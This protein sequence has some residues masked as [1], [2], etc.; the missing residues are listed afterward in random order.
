MASG[1]GR[2]AKPFMLGGA[3][4]VAPDAVWHSKETSTPPRVKAL[5]KG[6]M[7]DFVLPQLCRLAERPPGG[8]GWGHEI[9]F[10]GYRMQLRIA[11]GEPTLRTRKGLDWSDKFSAIVEAAAAL[12]DALVDGE[13]VA[14]NAEG[15]PDFSAL[16]AALS[17]CKTDDLVFFAFDLLYADG[18]D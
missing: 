15:V 16:Q 13:I 4:K 10:D 8:A 5:P 7:P 18:K 17:E 2:G 3:A 6:P 11:G 14:L 1:K 9:K 12:P